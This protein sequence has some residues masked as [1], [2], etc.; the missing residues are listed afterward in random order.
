MGLIPVVPTS[1]RVPLR[2]HITPA[3]IMSVVIACLAA[4]ALYFAFVQGRV[5]RPYRDSFQRG[6]MSVWNI[7]GGTWS[8]SDG[9]L[10][11]LSGAR[12]DKAI[13]GSAWWKDY[14]VQTDLRLNADPADSLWGDAG[15][16][17]RVSDPSIGVDSY[18]GY[19]VG[20]GSDGPVLLLGRANYSWVRL[21]SVPLGV[22]AV[23]GKWFHI[24]VLVK[25]CYFEATA[26]DM[27][28]RSQ[29]RLTYFDQDCSKRSGAVGVRTYGLLA[30]WRNFTVTQAE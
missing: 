21:S 3:A 30:S 12:G 11:N 4:M 5:L 14:V 10:D 28:G 17:L 15:L 24:K 7:Y 20:I 16:L 27:A 25:G 6:D 1:P 13:T 22:S 8:A 23:R 9:V 26:D 2:N 29:A 19:Y 18:D